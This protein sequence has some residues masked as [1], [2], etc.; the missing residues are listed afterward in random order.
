MREKEKEK[1]K[2]KKRKKLAEK[3]EKRKKNR[4]QKKRKR[5]LSWL[6][7]GLS[8]FVVYVTWAIKSVGGLKNLLP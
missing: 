1:K 6:E 5:N 2:E 8:R 3:K 7:I 4:K